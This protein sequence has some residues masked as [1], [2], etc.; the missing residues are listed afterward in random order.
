MMFSASLAAIV[1][2]SLII[3][4]IAVAFGGS[5]SGGLIP[6][7][8]I[9][10]LIFS[11]IHFIALG[12][13]TLILLNKFNLLKFK[14]VILTGFLIAIIPTGIH[15]WPLPDGQLFGKI[16]AKLYGFD[17][18]KNIDGIPTIWGWLIYLKETLTPGILFGIPAAF[19]FWYFYD[20]N[21]A[22]RPN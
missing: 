12:L 6:V 9:Y 22:Q 7:F 20:S 8:L 19:A 17:V 21:S 11:T 15:R 14:Y 16:E 1:T 13:P 2:P 18:V 4:I 3:A 5:P 10:G